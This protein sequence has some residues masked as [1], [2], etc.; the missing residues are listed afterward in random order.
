[1][2]YWNVSIRCTGPLMAAKEGHNTILGPF[3]LA[4]NVLT[5]L[6]LLIEMQINVVF[7]RNNKTYKVH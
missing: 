7:I 1:M 2:V 6:Y 4:E 3:Y 5:K